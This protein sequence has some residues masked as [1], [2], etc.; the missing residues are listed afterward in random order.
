MSN[1]FDDIL[2]AAF[3]QLEEQE[4]KENITNNNTIEP[5]IK[6]NE[7]IDT[8]ESD[9]LNSMLNDALNLFSKTTIVT[10][11]ADAENNMFNAALADLITKYLDVD[12]IREQSHIIGTTYPEWI[13]K[14]RNKLTATQ[15]E[16]HQTQCNSFIKFSKMMSE[17]NPKLSSV[18]AQ[19]S[20]TLLNADLP[21]EIRQSLNPSDTK[22]L[23]QFEEALNKLETEEKEQKQS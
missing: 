23:H 12:S 3:N 17:T 18:M 20:E 14:N 15:L 7:Q 19:F 9:I 5:E 8:S 13:Q 10:D 4:S 21:A 16:H 11:N 2:N 1:D 22:N 6:Q